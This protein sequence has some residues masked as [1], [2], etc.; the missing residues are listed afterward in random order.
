MLLYTPVKE[1]CFLVGSLYSSS[2]VSVITLAKALMSGIN[3]GLA[4]VARGGITGVIVH[5]S[6]SSKPMNEGA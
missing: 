6:S 3:G 5:I 1:H 2:N 4:G